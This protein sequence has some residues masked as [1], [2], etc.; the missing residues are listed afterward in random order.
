[1]LPY[2]FLAAAAALAPCAVAQLHV[3]GNSPDI[4]TAIHFANPGETIV[5]ADGVYT[6]PGN[7][8]LDFQGKDLVVRSANGAARCILDCGGSVA[9]PHRGFLFENG[10]T[11]ASVVEG[12]TIIGGRT[13]EGAIIDL[14]NGGG[15]R[16]RLDSSPTIR[17]CVFRDNTAGCWGGGVY[18]GFGGSPLI[19]GCLFEGNAADDGGGL[20]SWQGAQT[21]IRNSVFLRNVAS[22]AG[23]A[24]AEFGGGSIMLEGCTIAYNES[25]SWSIG[26]VVDFGIQSTIRNSILWGNSGS[27]QLNLGSAMA[28]RFSN[29]QGGAAG[30]GNLD[31]DPQFRADGYHLKASSPCIDAGSPFYAAAPGESDIDGQ[32]RVQGGRIDMGADETVAGLPGSDDPLGP[33]FRKR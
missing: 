9:D 6:G 18:V 10:E 28:V 11:R 32:A 13:A 26:G 15:I 2:R 31:V 8:D 24:I 3:P 29:V 20:F 12:F 14:F 27:A 30:E 21:E 7:T 23:G 33:I 4:K 5:V 25:P 1:V 16:I 17:N 22:N 19:V